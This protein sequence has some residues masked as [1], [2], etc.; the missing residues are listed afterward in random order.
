MERSQRLKEL[1]KEKILV[2][3]GAMGTALQS[4]GLSAQDFGGEAFEGCN[5]CS[6]SLAPTWSRRFIAGTSRRAPISSRPTPLARP[7]SSSRIP[8][9]QRKSLRDHPAAEPRSPARMA[10]KYS[11][12]EKPRFVA[13]SMGPT[14]KAISVTGG[15]TFDE[16][17]E[18][19][20]GAG[21]G[22]HRRRRR[23]P[24]DRDRAGHAQRQGGAARHRTRVREAGRCD[25]PIAVSRHHRADGHDARRPVRR[26]LLYVASSTSIS[27]TS[28][29]TARPAPSS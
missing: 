3:D 10:D 1:L 7:P 16:L 25:C 2:L 11:T 13:G 27:S 5:E 21:R 29:S 4:A 14:T 17:V 22:P 20:R 6:T 18:H 23:L 24:P 15:I 8:P 9:P 28:A 19:L 12:P 26:G